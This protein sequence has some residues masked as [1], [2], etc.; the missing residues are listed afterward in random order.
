MACTRCRSTGIDASDPCAHDA[1]SSRGG[2]DP[3]SHH[4]TNVIVTDAGDPGGASLASVRNMA[5]TGHARSALELIDDTGRTD[6]PALAMRA[7]LQYEIADYQGA[8]RT[9]ERVIAAADAGSD[10]WIIAS[11]SRNR[12]LLRM[13]KT[14]EALS[15]ARRLYADLVAHRGADDAATLSAEIDVAKVELTAGLAAD[16]VRDAETAVE[17]LRAKIG[18]RDPRTIVAYDRLA[19]AI[20]ASGRIAEAMAA[21]DRAMSGWRAGFG[22][23]HPAALACRRRQIDLFVR[24]GRAVDAL[25]MVEDIVA[26][27]RRVFG[28]RHP[29]SIAALMTGA[30]AAAAAGAPDRALGMAARARE[31]AR[32]ALRPEQPERKAADA[33][34]E[35]IEKAIGG[36]GRTPIAV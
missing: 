20:A 13:G 24:A 4:R 30:R 34:A 14:T 6:T 18:E 8:I 29:D 15:G 17:G 31:V 23:E 7:R 2:R 9:A 36:K 12:A 16:S 27:C 1:G 26:D 5:D 25:N 19:S 21:A 11:R 33:I 3:L 35:R 10:S 22:D 28:D 32:A